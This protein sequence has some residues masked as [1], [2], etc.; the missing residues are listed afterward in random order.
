MK[1][2]SEAGIQN[3]LD[4]AYLKAGHSAYF[5]EG[6]RAG[7]EYATLETSE[8]LK[9]RNEL[10]QALKVMEREAW[11]LKEYVVDQGVVDWEDESIEGCKDFDLAR[12]NSREAI[13]NTKTK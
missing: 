9:Q 1:H 5:G 11:T 8:L 10:L 2:L 13:N 4:T 6:F 7:V 3:A 12:K